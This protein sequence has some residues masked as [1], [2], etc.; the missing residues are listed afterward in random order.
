MLSSNVPWC[1]FL[2]CFWT[3][4]LNHLMAWSTCKCSF[5]ASH[6][7]GLCWKASILRHSIIHHNIVHTMGPNRL[8]ILHQYRSSRESNRNSVAL[9]SSLCCFCLF[10]FVSFCFVLFCFVLFCF[11]FLFLFLFLFV[12]FYQT[13]LSHNVFLY[14]GVWMVNHGWKGNLKKWNRKNVQLLLSLSSSE[15]KRFNNFSFNHII[16]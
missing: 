12:F 14:L 8:K 11:L 1:I 5:C 10:C 3:E 4:E 2:W 9:F 7:S 6:A 13:R 15:L 16:S